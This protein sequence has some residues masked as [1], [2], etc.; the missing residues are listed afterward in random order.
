MEQDRVIKTSYGGSSRPTIG[1][2]IDELTYEYQTG[3]WSGVVPAAEE[4]GINLL[5]FV[6]RSLHSPFGF[7]AQA[8]V[9]YSLVNSENVDGLVIMASSL[10]ARIGP[11]ETHEFLESYYPLPIV[12]VGL[13]LKGV[14]SV[15]V[16]NESGLRDVLVHLIKQHNHRRIAFIRGPVANEEAEL[17]YRTY[18]SVLQDHNIDVIPDLIAPGDFVRPSGAEA[19]AMLL[20]ERRAQFEAIVAA[21]DNMALGAL[22]ALQARGIRVPSDVV[23]V[24]FDDVE[25]TRLVTPP[26]TTVHQPL[27]EQGRQAVSMLLALMAGEQ[28]PDK[29]TLP[30]RAVIRQSCGCM[31][32]TVVQAKVGQLPKARQASANALIE[33]RD[34]ILASMESEMELAADFATEQ[35]AQ[36]LDAFASEMTGI[37][38]TFLPAL[39]EILSHAVT[40]DQDLALWHSALSALRRHT[41]P[42]I[43]DRNSLAQAEDLCQQARVMI[44]EMGQHAQAYRRLQAGQL[45][46]ALRGIGQSL[47][48]AV[49]VPGLMDILAQEMPE[50]GIPSSYVALYQGDTTPAEWAKLILAYDPRGRIKLSAEEQVIPSYQLMSSA[51]LRDG[52][53]HTFVVHPLYFREHQLGYMLMEMGPQEGATY[54]AVS[55]QLSSALRIALLFQQVESRALQL[56]TAAEVAQAASSILDPDALI[57]QVVQLVQ[58]RFSLYYAGLFLVDHTGEW[59]NEPNRWAVLQAGTGEAGRMMLERNHKLEIGGTSMIGWCIAN[60]QARI[61]LD[62]GE[63]AVRFENPLLPGTHSEMAMPLISRGQAIGALSIQSTH[64]A[65]FSDEDVAVLRTMAG[66]L[67]NAI[68]N[69]RLFERTQ[70]ALMEMES[71]HRRYLQREWS[72][73]LMSAENLEYETEMQGAPPLGD[74]VMPEIVKALNVSGTATVVN[75]SGGRS[76]P[77]RAALVTPINLRGATIGALGVHDSPERQWTPEEISMAE[78]IS[79]RMALAAENLRL[80]DETQRRA[81]REQ[82]VSEITAEMRASLNPENVLKAAAEEIYHALGLDSVSIR[83]ATEEADDGQE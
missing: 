71:V 30:A 28:V 77:K 81:A 63:E 3:V 16:D 12:S 54:N 34:H 11:E 58:E 57:Q 42:L 23:L 68:A 56:Q 6:G 60:K 5:T 10:C 72:E 69:A 13:A 4:R 43:D 35:V 49:Q 51:A 14:P 36:L 41:L 47:I 80:L 29:V 25:E 24:G 61:A 50:L 66:Q 17:R 38:N 18:V 52:Q 31:A 76:G 32:Q 27:F 75:A 9:I 1:L 65:A 62:V 37:P 82:L 19:I 7:E 20:D 74:T 2:L 15:L 67:A 40:S 22:E 45:T 78:I 59:T 46:A 44:G 48:T 21:N 79:E 53:R 64:K 39:D 33:Q 70:A 73:Y 55:S 83:L 26:L 8:N